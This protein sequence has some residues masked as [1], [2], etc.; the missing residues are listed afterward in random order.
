MSDAS[1][2]R[3]EKDVIL[4]MRMDAMLNSSPASFLSIVGALI[5][6]YVYWSPS[7]ATVLLFWL[8]C[9]V[10][11][12][13]TNL[14]STVLY[15]RRIPQ[16]WNARSWARF[17][18]LMHLLSGLSWG[19]GGGW[20][21]SFANEHQALVTVTIGLA[22][23]TVSIPSVVHLRAYNLFHLPIF[24]PYAVGAALSTLQF[25]W[26]IAIGFF[27]LGAFAVVI[28]RVL[29]DQLT[30]ALRLS[31]ENRRLA[32]RLEERSAELE[33]ANRELEI[34]SH[35]DPLTGL[36]NRR[37]LMSFARA[38]RGRCA[39]MIVDIDHFKSYN[40]SYGH[41][42][43]DACLVTVARALLGS[44]RPDEDIVARLGGEEF[45]VI[46]T[47]VDA[48]QAH[49]QAEAIRAGVQ[50]LPV[51][52]TNGVRR[53]VTVSIG[54]STRDADQQKT[55]ATLMEEADAAVYRAKADGRNVVCIG[56]SSAARHVA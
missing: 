18:C 16:S 56:K 24:W 33:A 53:K 21:L 32:E 55:L 39:V 43:G 31:I 37:R 17:V 9:I 6:L 14:V 27:L 26:P 30:N 34:E 48:Q 28:G 2:D 41:V 5:A 49:E 51:A 36:A 15:A 11:V 29:G 8:G 50:A 12:A 7:T 42:E 1:A 25:K 20:M 4:S 35:T 45:A 54:L 23:V 38:V 46:L 44:V 47:D 3:N 22:A 13:V 19:V 40:D 10:A 52:G